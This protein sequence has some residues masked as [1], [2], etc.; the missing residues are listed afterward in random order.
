MQ[1]M[2][3]IVTI[4]TAIQTAAANYGMFVA[5]RFMAGFAVGYITLPNPLLT[6][7][8]IDMIEEWSARSPST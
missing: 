5:G 7:E 3:V 2:C 6:F 8:L 1:I 4:G